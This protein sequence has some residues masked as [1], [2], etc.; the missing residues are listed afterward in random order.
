MLCDQISEPTP[1][2][3]HI[4]REGLT[5][6][7]RYGCGGLAL[8]IS[9][10][11]F[12]P[13]FRFLAILTKKCVIFDKRVTKVTYLL[14]ISNFGTLQFVKTCP[15]IRFLGRFLAGHW[16]SGGNFAHPRLCTYVLTFIRESPPPRH[17]IKS[18]PP[19][20]CPRSGENYWLF[21]PA[22]VQIGRSPS[23]SCFGTRINKKYIK[24]KRD[25]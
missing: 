3:D 23:P 18:L 10:V 15:I 9:G 1:L 16:V 4:T 7:G 2:T 13:G 12:C 17:I 11:N 5:N 24:L 22:Q 25:R 14:K 20:H 6:K 21:S 19:R 8:G